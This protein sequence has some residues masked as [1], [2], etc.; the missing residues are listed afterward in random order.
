MNNDS[1][2]YVFQQEVITA[3]AKYSIE[4]IDEVQRL[5]VSKTEKV[6]PGSGS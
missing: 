5:T 2:I 1:M 3:S 6:N 4:T